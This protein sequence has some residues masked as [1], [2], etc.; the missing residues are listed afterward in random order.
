LIHKNE[1][2]LIIAPND[3]IVVIT[4][5]EIFE[6]E[7]NYDFVTFYDGSEQESQV[8]LSRLSGIILTIDQIYSR[9]RVLRVTFTR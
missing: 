1:I 7:L 5:I 2:I 4:G 8:Q 3:K 6:T 9:G